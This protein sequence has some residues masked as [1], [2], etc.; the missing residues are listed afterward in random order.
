[1]RREVVTRALGWKS[2]VAAALLFVAILAGVSVAQ[3]RGIGAALMAFAARRSEPSVLASGSFLRTSRDERGAPILDVQLDAVLEQ[4]GSGV[5][6]QRPAL[7]HLVQLIFGDDPEIESR[8]V[9]DVLDRVQRVRITSEGLSLTVGRRVIVRTLA[10]LIGAEGTL[11]Q[12]TVGEVLDGLAG[13]RL[14]PDGIAGLLDQD[15]VAA[16]VGG[17]LDAAQRAI[18]ARDPQFLR[19]QALQRRWALV[20]DLVKD[21]RRNG[22]SDADPNVLYNEAHDRLVAQQQRAAIPL[23]DGYLRLEAE[24]KAI[25][26]GAATRAE[27]I[28]LRWAARRKVF[29][30]PVVG[31]LFGRDEAIE[32]YEVDR[33]AL[34]ADQALSAADKAKRLQARREALKVELAAQGTYVS[35]ANEARPAAGD[36]RDV[37]DAEQSGAEEGGTR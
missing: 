32:R 5:V 34:E 16:L 37:P 36:A 29:E 19:R 4:L 22:F 21:M 27:R 17:A 2:L 25:Q 24:M 26:V 6:L 33:L 30:E 23:L 8:R 7:L 14:T 11:P 3:H 12:M 1:M 31:L 10:H 13:A 28:P 20:T 9:A 15:G 35:F 18:P